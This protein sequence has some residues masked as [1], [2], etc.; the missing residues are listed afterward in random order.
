MGKVAVHISDNVAET[1]FI[2]LYMKALETKRPRPFFNDQYACRLVDLVDYDFSKYKSAVMSSVG[3]GIRAKYFDSVAESFI[4]SSSK[5]V[6][7]SVGCGLDTRSHRIDQDLAQ[8]ALFYEVDL[9]EVIHLRNK[10]IP[11]TQ[12]SHYIKSSMFDTE[13]LDFVKKENSGADI[14]FIS[15]GVLMYFQEDQVR[16]FFRNIAE[17]FDSSLILFDALNGWMCR[18]SK[19]HDTVKRT[20][21]SF[22]WGCD[23]LLEIEAWASNLKVISIK[24]LTDFNDWKRVGLMYWIIKIIPMLKNSSFLVTCGIKQSDS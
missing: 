5:P 3:V 13:W 20:N 15:E 21:A 14:L 11:P 2:P 17:R 1:L 7:V 8:R 23:D 6:V 18:N 19:R 24:K 10:L 16:T 12:N 22:L 9:P 4:I